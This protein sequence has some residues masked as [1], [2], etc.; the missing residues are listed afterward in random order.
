MTAAT[1]AGQLPRTSWSRITLRPRLADKA[2]MAPLTL[3][4][5]LPIS[6]RQR[7]THA[8]APRCTT[9]VLRQRP[10]RAGTPTPRPR[11]GT[12]QTI[13]GTPAEQSPRPSGSWTTRRRRSAAKALTAQLSARDRQPVV[14]GK[15]VT[16]AVVRRCTT[17][18]R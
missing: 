6:H 17:L 18:G 1:P 16:P 14:Q 3:H 10:G 11:A 9:W 8:V 2:P 13:A 4:D 12:P 7:A 15:Q 5:A